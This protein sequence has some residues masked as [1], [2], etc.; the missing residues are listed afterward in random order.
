MF[1]H[2]GVDCV[3]VICEDLA[4]FSVLINVI[5]PY[6]GVNV[7]CVIGRF[8]AGIKN[9]C[10]EVFEGSLYVCSVFRFSAAVFSNLLGG[11]QVGI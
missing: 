4:P 10:G 9:E 8:N 11:F 5:F 7:G 3:E 2:N 6:F 1:P